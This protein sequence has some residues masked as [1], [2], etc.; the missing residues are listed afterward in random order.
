VSNLKQANLS[1]LSPYNDIGD[2]DTSMNRPSALIEIAEHQDEKDNLMTN[3]DEK[4]RMAMTGMT[5][6]SKKKTMKSY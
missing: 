3:I 2:H 6:M 5:G 1:T 4:S